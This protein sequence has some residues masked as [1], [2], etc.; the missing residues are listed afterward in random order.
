MNPTIEIVA[1]PSKKLLG[2]WL[3]SLSDKTGFVLQYKT[4]T[5]P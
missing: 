1:I 2:H 3:D 5:L 4:G